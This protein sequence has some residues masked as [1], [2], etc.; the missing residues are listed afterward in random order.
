MPD[1]NTPI[2]SSKHHWFEP[3]TAILMAVASLATAW[4][5]YQNSCWSSI[6]SGLEDKADKLEREASV[7]KLESHQ[8]EAVQMAAVMEVVDA[9]LD[10]DEKRASFHTS[11]FGGELK[12]AYEK[13]MALKPFENPQAPPHPLVPALYT[14]RHHQEIKENLTQAAQD[15][16]QSN[17]AG[18]TASIYL[19]NTV[20][21]ASVLFFAGTMGKFSQKHVRWS[22]LTFAVVLFSYALV[23][24]LML[25][26]A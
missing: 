16:A 22:S 25:P 1:S 23:R 15:E 6:S 11:R 12:T 26:V 3:V 20:I 9:M 14:P 18:H 17:K 5:S 8:L 10:G 2:S 13:W 4:C 19:S 21:L 24:L 7:L